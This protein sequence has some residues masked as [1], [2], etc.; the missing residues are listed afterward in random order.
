MSLLAWFVAAFCFLSFN[1][2]RA[3]SA[4]TSIALTS[5]C[6]YCTGNIPGPDVLRWFDPADSNPHSNGSRGKYQLRRNS[7]GCLLVY[8]CLNLEDIPENSV[9]IVL[10]NSYLTLPTLTC[11]IERLCSFSASQLGVA[12]VASAV[13]MILLF[14]IQVRWCNKFDGLLTCSGVWLSILDYEITRFS[15]PSRSS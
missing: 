13:F 9:D 4:I 1:E 12:A 10:A 14:P 8:H 5:P 7:R 2:L 11:L 3:I 15:L 6:L